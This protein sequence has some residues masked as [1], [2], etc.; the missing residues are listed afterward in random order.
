LR[1]LLVLG[2]CLAVALPALAAGMDP[3]ARADETPPGSDLE[4][5]QVLLPQPGDVTRPHA[6]GPSTLGLP[7]AGA[8]VLRFEPLGLDPTWFEPLL[9]KR[10]EPNE[11]AMPG[12]WVGALAAPVEPACPVE[13]A[14]TDA[15]PSTCLAGDD[16]GAAPAASVETMARDGDAPPQRDLDVGLVL[17]PLP[18][19]YRAARASR[20]VHVDGR[21]DEDDWAAAPSY[22]LAFELAPSEGATPS[23]RTEVRFLHDDDKIGRAHV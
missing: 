4:T 17:D 12:W 20:P 9:L 7:G 3:A 22:D 11:E 15:A 18:R 5:V 1:A 8:H 19:D 6:I 13:D 16:R 23:E 10:M 21:L 2:T 14:A